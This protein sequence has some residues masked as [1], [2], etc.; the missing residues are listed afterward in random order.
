MNSKE[1]SISNFETVKILDRKVVILL[2][3]QNE[4]ERD[5]VIINA[6]V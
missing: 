1:Y 4:F 2:D 6:T 5:D 3:P